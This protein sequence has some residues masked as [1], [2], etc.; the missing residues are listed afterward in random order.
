VL[1]RAHYW[2]LG[3][4]VV[5]CLVLLNL[6]PTAAGRLK[7]G[8]SA[9]FV[10]L[11]GL[12]GAGQAFVDR[13]SYASLNRTTL[14]T[15]IERLR[16]ENDQ[17]RMAADQGSVLQTENA[18]LRALLG[19]QSRAPWKLRAA[20][21]IAREPTTW[22]RTVTIDYGSRDGARTNQP[23]LTNS[24]LVGRIREVGL[25]HSQVALIGDPECGVSAVVAETRDT[26]II[27]EA[28]AAPDADG[29]VV[30]RTLQRSPTTMPGHR[31][32]TSGLG[33]VFPS[34]IPIGQ[35]VDTRP[36]EGGL[37]TEARIRLAANLGQLEEIWV[38]MP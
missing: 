6:P 28:R 30:M 34:G 22:W 4:I 33:G 38:L 27:L 37:Y 21:V 9:L 20:T 3:A 11:L 13:A 35:I 31:V 18:K 32:L 5:L 23:V 17:L 1:K 15:E 25:T 2:V 8:V 16:T 19:W 12:S 26:G 24:G 29:L 36:V 14:I 7:L 10:P